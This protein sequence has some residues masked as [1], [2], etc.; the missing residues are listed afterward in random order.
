M[1]FDTYI[2]WTVL[3][4][5]AMEKKKMKAEAMQGGNYY[6]VYRKPNPYSHGCQPGMISLVVKLREKL[7]LKKNGI[8]LLPGNI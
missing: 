4:Y 5:M 3:V 8:E 6:V 7:E 2:D 1:L